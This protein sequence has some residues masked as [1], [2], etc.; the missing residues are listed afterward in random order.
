M[1]YATVLY[2]DEEKICCID[3]AG[4]RAFLLEDFFEKF[5]GGSGDNPDDMT[6]FI[7]A[8]QDK[9]TD[10]IALFFGARPELAIPLADLTLLAPIPGPKRNLVCLGKNYQAHAAEIRDGIFEDNMPPYPI[11]FTKPDHT[12]IGSGT[13]IL[14]HAEATSKLDYEIELA[15]IIGKGGINIPKE[16]AHEHIFGYT[17]AN[18][19]SARELQR[20]HTQWFKGKSLTTHC[21]MGPW[22]VHKTMIAFPPALDLKCYVNEELR[23]VGNSADLIFDIPT[24]ISD[25]SKGYELKSGDIILTGTPSGVG[26]GFDPPKF[27][28][29][30]D[31]IRC[32]IQDIGTISNTVAP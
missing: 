20:R 6:D 15:F 5:L 12:V 13:N 22:I 30:G 24:I 23:Q 16:K 10:D 29:D 31:V 32:E 17:I 26:L 3:R 4:E 28:K 19:I 8:Y 2:K 14:S 1:V 25:L 18:D 27:L 21:P 9:W 7:S 11:Y